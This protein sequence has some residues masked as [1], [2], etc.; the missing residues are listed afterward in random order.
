MNHTKSSW[1]LCVQL[2]CGIAVTIF[3]FQAHAQAGT[4]TIKVNALTPVVL[5]DASKGDTLHLHVAGGVDA[6][7]WE[8]S[9]W[10][11]T[12]PAI[13][14]LAINT[15][16]LPG[17]YVNLPISNPSSSVW[18]SFI[19]YHH[20]N[21]DN[22]MLVTRLGPYAA[23]DAHG[24]PNHFCPPTFNWQTALFGI[25]KDL[26]FQLYASTTDDTCAGTVIAG[27]AS[28]T[29]LKWVGFPP[30]VSGGTIQF[31]NG[32]APGWVGGPGACD[33][34]F[35]TGCNPQSQYILTY[36]I[37]PPG[38]VPRACAPTENGYF[39][40]GCGNLM[41]CGCL[42]NCVAVCGV[43]DGC[44]GFCPDCCPGCSPP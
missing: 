6:N 7:F 34:N 1:R 3:A 37:V 12:R 32:N 2:L 24:L 33:C 20:R 11:P 22:S 40:D 21:F 43:P 36:S 31:T 41:L 4:W 18:F 29:G 9:T 5:R 8:S 25:T 14:G 44:G 30:P 26:F 39:W 15:N 16:N 10:L 38:C 17:T 19:A 28:A 35:F 13:N 27:D 23:P 42:P